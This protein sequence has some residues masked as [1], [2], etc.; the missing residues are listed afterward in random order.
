MYCRIF[1][2]YLSKPTF[3]TVGNHEGVPI[4]SFAPHFALPKFWPD[5]IYKEL[6]DANDPWLKK[7]S[8]SLL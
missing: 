2:K 4:N 7:P 6:K 3:W 8:K 5:W 1:R